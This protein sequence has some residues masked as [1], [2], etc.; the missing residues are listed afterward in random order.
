MP[1]YDDIGILTGAYAN[2]SLAAALLRIGEI[3]P[4]AEIL[5]VGRHSCSLRPTRA[6]SRW[7]A[8]RSASTGRFF[9]SSTATARGGSTGR[10]STSTAGTSPSPPSWALACTSCTPTCSAGTGWDKRVVRTLEGSFEEL[11]GCRRSPE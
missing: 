11:A 5:S 4:A 7:P 2:F 10:R 3:A 9:T 6:S 1:I 8:F